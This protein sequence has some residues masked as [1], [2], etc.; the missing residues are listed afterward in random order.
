[1]EEWK[2][3]STI[4]N[5]GTRW[6]W[7]VSFKLRHALSRGSNPGTHWVGPEKSGRCGEEKNV[8]HLPGIQ[9]QFLGRPA[10]GL[11]AIRTEISGLLLNSIY[12]ITYIYDSNTKSNTHNKRNY[13]IVTRLNIF[14]FSFH[15][16]PS[17]L[18]TFTVFRSKGTQEK[19]WIMHYNYTVLM[20]CLYADCYN[21]SRIVFIWI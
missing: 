14:S 17:C 5:P 11:F 3:R 9:P 1:V 18:P 8:L 6:R 16:L 13:H 7:V 21:F 2:Y 12:N 10:R 15:F 20:A 4:L 19:L